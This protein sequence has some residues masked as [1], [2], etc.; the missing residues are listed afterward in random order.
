MEKILY[1]VKMRASKKVFNE[2]SKEILNEKLKI[3]DTIHISGAERII[4]KGNI[5][6]ATNSLIKRALNHSRG[7]ADFINIS[8]NK[9]NEKDIKYVKALDIT[10]IDVQTCDKGLECAVKILEKVGISKEK[11]KKIISI[12]KNINGMRGAMILDINSLERLEPDFERG[13]RATSI[14]W[15]ENIKESLNYLLT[16]NFLNNNHIKEAIALSTKVSSFSGIIAEICMS[17]D[18]GYVAGYVASKEFGY[19]RITHMKDENS[20]YGGR[21]FLFDSSN[22][23]IDECIKYLEKQVVIL[24]ELPKIKGIISYKDFIKSHSDK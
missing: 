1:N 11:S 8:I 16:N 5:E 15:E 9:I 2:N 4:S 20:L 18:K 10:T 19:V 7:E 23:S 21:I 6:E 24:N 13:I 14:D 12:F 17:D 22:T 3:D